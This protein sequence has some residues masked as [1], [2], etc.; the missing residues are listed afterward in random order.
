MLETHSRAVISIRD[1][2]SYKDA[3]LFSYRNCMKNE[4]FIE[5]FAVYTLHVSPKTYLI[6][7]VDSFVDMKESVIPCF[8]LRL[9]MLWRN[10]SVSSL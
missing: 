2:V 10:C 5:G 3:K 6:W 1:E 7:H 9:C 8:L 4:R